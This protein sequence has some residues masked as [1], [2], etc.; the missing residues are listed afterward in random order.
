MTTF[1]ILVID[2]HDTI[3]MRISR[4]SARGA[5]A[6]NFTPCNFTIVIAE[7]RGCGAHPVSGHAHV[8][9]PDGCLNALA[10]GDDPCCFPQLLDDPFS[11]SLVFHGV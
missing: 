3:I 10:L 7:P 2:G 5:S 6:C 9:L 8:D 1:L 4:V 11:G